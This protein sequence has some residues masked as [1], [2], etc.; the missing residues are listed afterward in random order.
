MSNQ[1]MAVCYDSQ[2]CIKCYSCVVSC[3][4][5]NRTRMQHNGSKDVRPIFYAYI[6]L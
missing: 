4:V 3:S 5:E 6:K 1:A 2:S